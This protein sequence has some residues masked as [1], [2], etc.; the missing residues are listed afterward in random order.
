MASSP[1]L[2]CSSL[3]SGCSHGK[4]ETP[5]P[6]RNGANKVALMVMNGLDTHGKMADVVNLMIPLY[7]PTSESVDAPDDDMTKEALSSA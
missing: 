1:R 7:N 3:K 6:R 4:A 2:S 5:A